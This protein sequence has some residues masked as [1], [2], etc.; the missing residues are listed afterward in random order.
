MARLLAAALRARG[1][2]VVL[3]RPRSLGSVVGA[4]RAR[5]PAGGRT[6]GQNRGVGGTVRQRGVALTRSVADPVA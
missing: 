2:E 5:Y 3:D 6:P 4:R 1:P